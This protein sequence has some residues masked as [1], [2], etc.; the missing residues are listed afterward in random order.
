M[1]R[2]PSKAA[3][4]AEATIATL[5]AQPGEPELHAH[6]VIDAPLRAALWR[7]GLRELVRPTLA[8]LHHAA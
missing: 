6:G 2:S 4:G 7:E 5:A 8:A 1:L 3:S